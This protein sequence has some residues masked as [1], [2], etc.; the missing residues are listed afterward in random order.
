MLVFVLSRV[1]VCLVVLQV[2]VFVCLWWPDMVPNQRQLFIVVSDWGS[3]LGSH[4]PF[5]VRGF[6]LYVQL[7][8][9]SI[10]ISITFRSF[11]YFG[12]CS[13]FNK[14]ECTHTTLR[15]GPIHIMNVTGGVTQTVCVP[16]HRLVSKAPLQWQIFCG[17][18]Q[19]NYYPLD[20]I[21]NRLFIVFYSLIP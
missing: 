20:V 10:H 13:F 18:C 11:C 2:Q 16:L 9:C 6:L 15:L 19:L 14:E 1:F 5:C 21:D 17:K 12:Q 7:P 3:Y 8:V 4:F